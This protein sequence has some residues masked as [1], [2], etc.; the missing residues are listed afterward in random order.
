MALARNR[1]RGPVPSLR[2][3]PVCDPDPSLRTLSNLKSVG[4]GVL[5]YTVDYDDVFPPDMASVN[6]AWPFISTYVVNKTVQDSLNPASPMFRGVPNLN[7][8]KARTVVNPSIKFEFFDSMPWPGDGR[9]MVLYLDG[10]A[11]KL[12]DPEFQSAEPEATK[13]FK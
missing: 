3:D 6:A 5:Q 7:G 11:T 13:P 10:H 2:R 1:P 4:R 12:R 8:K 9:R